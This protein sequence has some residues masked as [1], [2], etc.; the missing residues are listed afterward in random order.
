MDASN[1]LK[2]GLA[3]GSIKLFAA[4]TA[5]ECRRDIEKDPGLKR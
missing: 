2:R 5:V 1:I 4:T 3:Q